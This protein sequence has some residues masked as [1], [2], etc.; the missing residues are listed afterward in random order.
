[1][2]DVRLDDTAQEFIQECAR[3]ATVLDV[4]GHVAYEQ[5][6]VLRIDSGTVPNAVAA[7]LLHVRDNTGKQPHIY[8]EWTEG[9]PG[10]NLLRFLAFGGGEVLASP[11]RYFGG[12]SRTVLGGRTPCRMRHRSRFRAV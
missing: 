1:V 7:L 6:R 10:V 12:P 3:F 8:F 2:R 11:A 4:Q 9:H 5:H